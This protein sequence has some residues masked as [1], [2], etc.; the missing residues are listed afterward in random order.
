MNFGLFK[1]DN[2]NG[3]AMYCKPLLFLAVLFSAVPICYGANYYVNDNSTTGDAYCTAVGNAAN[4]GLSASTP[5][6]TLTNLLSVYSGTLTAG[7]VIYIDAGTYSD[8]NLNLNING[9]SIIGAGPAKTVFD[10]N[11]ASVDA[12]RLFLVTGDNITL[13]G[14][15]VTDYNYGVGGA[16]AIQIS[17]ASNLTVNNVLTDLNRPGGGSSTIMIDGG[18]SVI[19]N[20]GGSNCNA[21]SSI[22]GGGVNVEGNGNTVVFNNYSFSN[23]SK[24]FQGGSGLYIEGDNT[25]TVTVNNSILADNRNTSYGGAIYISGANLNVNNTCFSNNST[26]NGSGPKYGGAVTVGRGATVTFTNCLF[27]NNTVSNSG[28]GGAIGINTQYGTI[29]TTATVNVNTCTF[30]GNSSNSSG[31]HLYARVGSSNAAILNVN[32]C[33]LA[34]SGQDIKNGNSA[35]INVQNSGNPSTSGTVNFINTNAPSS[36]ASPSYPVLQGSCYGLILPVE[37]T[38]F[39]TQ[40]NDSYAELHWSTST[41]HNNAY[42]TIEH[43]SENGQFSVLNI[44]EGKLNS[45]VRSD[46]HLTDFFAQPGINYYRL[47]QTDTDG[48]TKTL[49]TV[50]LNNTCLTQ[51]PEMTCVFNANDHALI[52]AYYIDQSELYDITIYNSM[53]QVL[54]KTEQLFHASDRAVNVELNE[55]LSTGVY[56]VQLSNDNVMLSDKVMVNK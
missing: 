37:L 43:A 39:S 3:V 27:E 4:N 7:D 14:F 33:T 56:F 21:V 32:N 18:S 35:T 38:D 51:E 6:A 26:Y 31:H 30:T 49:S 55:H 19:F 15:S 29:G 41:E 23:N 52:I 16:S 54:Q 34:A 9:I 12:N 25:T 2:L 5:K 22:A 1:P 17:G 24:D 8:K 13:Q 47:S 28:N 53:G 45:T 10:N 36:T 44:V 48:R 50:S 11:F 42:F 46:Y 20:G 40:C